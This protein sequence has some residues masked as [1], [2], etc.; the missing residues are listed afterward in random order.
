MPEEKKE[1][2]LRLDFHKLR[3][4]WSKF[5]ELEKLQPLILAPDLLIYRENR[6]F[7]AAVGRKV[8]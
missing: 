2:D 4:K 3:V 7:A 1:E 8:S 6:T 5:R